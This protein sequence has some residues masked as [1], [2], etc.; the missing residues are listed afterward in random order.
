MY[1]N[2]D[3]GQNQTIQDENEI[4]KSL[5][6]PL[7]REIIKSLGQKNKMSFTDLKNAVNAID[8]PS[9]SYHLKSL[10]I[11]IKQD[12]NLYTLTNQGR[13]ALILIN[14]IDQ[15]KRVEKGKKRFLIANIITIICWTIVS[16]AV[17][18][19]I[20]PYVDE[21]LRIGITIL[22]NVMIQINSVVIWNLWAS[23]WKYRV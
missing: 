22:F 9:L 2:T 6:H 20:A 18:I 4:Y 19:A 13:A 3:S 21:S 10:E 16:F 7:R 15:S 14:S 12:K 1:S 8:S 5:S 11:L 17:P 23:S